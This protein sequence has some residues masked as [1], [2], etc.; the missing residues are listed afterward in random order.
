MVD[1]DRFSS[2]M[3]KGVLA[4]VADLVIVALASLALLFANLTVTIMT[5]TKV[6]IPYDYIVICAVF[7]ALLPFRD[8]Y[9]SPSRHRPGLVLFAIIVFVSGVVLLTSWRFA[10]GLHL[11]F[12]SGKF[13]LIATV[14]YIV[15]VFN[16]L[17]SSL[18]S[19]PR[20]II[21][22]TD[23]I[24]V[25]GFAYMAVRS[26]PAALLTFITYK[27]TNYDSSPANHA[28]IFCAF[29]ALV[30]LVLEGAKKR[31]ADQYGGKR[32]IINR[33]ETDEE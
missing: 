27:L 19:I 16:L 30:L 15:S 1:D 10:I 3:R 2:K 5:N 12:V 33:S 31:M 26:I 29:L 11:P 6:A 18:P 32:P 24:A 22:R 8:T 23:T 20:S 14:L 25:H 21:V 28:T 4:A 17:A 13:E 9:R 7:F